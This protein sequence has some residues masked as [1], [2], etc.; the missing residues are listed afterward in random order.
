MSVGLFDKITVGSLTLENRINVA[1][2]CQYSA[3]KGLMNEWHLQH[4]IQMG[5]SA[6]GLVML[7]STAVEEIGRI[8]HHCLG[9]YNDDC[10]SSIKSNLQIEKKNLLC[11]LFYY[12]LNISLGSK[13]NCISFQIS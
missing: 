5:L 11:N 1:P 7:E 4:L 9:L 6:S 12:H 13:F 8:T 3:N 10:E 2:M